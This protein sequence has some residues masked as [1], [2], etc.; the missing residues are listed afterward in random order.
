MLNRLNQDKVV[1]A[2]L[3]AISFIT[4]WPWLR[5]TSIFT[6]GDW[7][8]VSLERYRDFALF[9]PIW[10]TD[11]FGSTSA[12][13][14]YY[15]IRLFE[16]FL[17]FIGSNFAINEKI[18]YMFPILII[19]PIGAFLLARAYVGRW[20]AGLAAIVYC[21]NTAFLFNQVGPLT[22]EMNYALTPF[23]LY[24]FR[25]FVWNPKETHNAVLAG[26]VLSVMVLYEL[27]ISLI[28]L[29]LGL[30]LW[31]FHL[32]GEEK[33]RSYILRSIKPL[34]LLFAV[35]IGTQLFWI[36][37]YVISSRA[38]TFSDVLSRSLF[39]SF[40]DI[41]N[42]LTLH[43][44]FWTGA[45]PATF[46]VQPIPAIAWLLPLLAFGYLLFLSKFRDNR[47]LWEIN[48][49]A[50]IGLVGV[51]LVKQVNPPFTDVY[52]WLFNN[53]PGF[54]AF[55]ESSKFYLMATIG[56]MIMI[57]ATM[58]FLA[59]YLVSEPKL[60]KVRAHWKIGLAAIP[61]ALVAVLF[62]LN[63]GPLIST[64]FRTLFIP[65]TMPTAY[66]AFNEHV[67][68]QPEFFRVA[69][70]PSESRWSIN[71]SN[72]PKLTTSALQQGVWGELSSA[73]KSSGTARDKLEILFSNSS[74]DTL[75][76]R[77]SV[78]YVVVPARDLANEDDFYKF[79]GNDQSVYTKMLDSV[80][81]LQRVDLG[82]PGLVVYE[83]KGYQKYISAYVAN[84]FLERTN[85]ISNTHDFVQGY[86]K[87]PFNF[88]MPRPNDPQ[89]AYPSTEVQDIFADIERKNVGSSTVSKQLDTVGESQ[90]HYNTNSR[91]Y[92]YQ[93]AGNN[94]TVYSEL[95]EDLRIDGAD[96]KPNGVDKQIVLSRPVSKDRVYYITLD[97]RTSRLQ[98]DE[99]E[100]NLGIVHSELR[101]YQTA[102]KNIIDNVSF[103]KGLWQPS[104]G[105]CNNY[106]GRSDVA[107]S[108]IAE[109]Q[110]ASGFAL[111]LEAE[112]HSACT[113][114]YV[115]LPGGSES[116]YLFNFGY[117]LTGT[118]DAAYEL[119]FNNS[120]KS[121]HWRHIK[122]YDRSW[123]KAF[124]IVKVPNGATGANMQI[125]GYPNYLL[126]GRA[127]TDYG[128]FSAISLELLANL[129]ERVAPVYAS[130][131]MTSQN[132][133][134][135]Y[136]GAGNQN[137][138]NNP[139][140]EKGLWRDRVGDC[141]AYDQHSALGMSLNRLVHSDGNASLE[142]RATRH[143]ACTS[144]E[145]VNV[146]ENENY[147]LTF[148]YQSPNAPAMEYYV[149][150]NDPARSSLQRSA[151]IKDDKWHTQSSQIKVPLG[152]TQMSIVVYAEAVDGRHEVIN[153]YDNFQLIKIPDIKGQYYLTNAEMPKLKAPNSVVTKSLHPTKKQITAQGTSTSFYLAMSESYNPLWRLAAANDKLTGINSLIPG[154]SAD[155]IPDKDHFKLN[156]FENGW[157]IDVD[158]LCKQ[159]QHCKQNE[160]GTYD[161]ELI[162]EFTPQRWLYVGEAVSGFTL[163][164]CLAYL[165]WAARR[166]RSRALK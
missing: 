139:S 97:G 43:H 133:R 52:A 7:W 48:Y 128:D 36:L 99:G 164:T 112:R 135:S 25:K 63:A 31:I 152:S 61:T 121:K 145:P 74:T 157:Y 37:P 138:I 49:W 19:A 114:T 79:Y 136:P 134:L 102:G 24:L 113:N 16:G 9:S 38:V 50:L 67:A 93:I 127:S 73:N 51:F 123:H 18:F 71:T 141:N 115:N 69:W 149:S 57:P 29:G 17:T 77:A 6:S 58:Q 4:H 111:R 2:L 76:D 46:V 78:K 56:Y 75:L 42:G 150:F 27:R 100:H 144:N 10:V 146:D 59:N 126:E 66:K 11:N 122:A 132:P 160:D 68:K 130:Q 140:F 147:L 82:T 72:H 96:F 148:D 129:D 91:R 40:S 89:P 55:R 108:R 166:K 110:S 26:L 94:I 116:Y 101:I 105:D 125:Y 83:N 161:I 81:Y 45:R 20:Y 90:L 62:L 41:S 60:R 34:T 137:L 117:R 120:D 65:R 159:Q 13:P 154:A 35:L 107:M 54:S 23:F 153:R 44:P 5:L 47:R 124:E 86:L 131:K 95:Q 21:F 15:L 33:R 104:V 163:L 162:A 87:E 14:H 98:I 12:T 28:A 143:T 106:D 85:E 53:V 64:Q 32:L 142:L 118:N 92:S 80:P 103:A 151:R 39:V 3:I 84:H 8:Y 119:T 165:V 156:D 22:I 88:V 158:K 70:V 109:S 1:I 155:T 30:G